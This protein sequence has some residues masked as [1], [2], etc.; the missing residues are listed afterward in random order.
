MVSI[1]GRLEA[2]FILTNSYLDVR[3]S[4]LYILNESGYDEIVLL[5]KRP[6]QA[7]YVCIDGGPYFR[8][9]AR[10]VSE[11]RDDETMVLLRWPAALAL[12][13]SCTSTRPATTRS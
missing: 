13:G 9:S 11:G 6:L 5:L 10:R 12:T 4:S 1:E 2:G 8:Y 7:S 3:D